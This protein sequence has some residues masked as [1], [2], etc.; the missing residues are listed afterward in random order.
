[1]YKCFYKKN[2]KIVYRK[3]KKSVRVVKKLKSSIN[4]CETEITQ[5]YTSKSSGKIVTCRGK[6]LEKGQKTRV[7]YV[8]GK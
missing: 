7:V 3:Q 1:V 8:E 4:Q 2:N 6:I 5:V